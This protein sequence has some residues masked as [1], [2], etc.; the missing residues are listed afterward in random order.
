MEPDD[1]GAAPSDLAAQNGYDTL[2]KELR[3]LE[4]RTLRLPV[5][6][7]EGGGDEVERN[8][9]ARERGPRTW[10]ADTGGCTRRAYEP[11][12]RL[13]SPSEEDY[14]IVHRR[15]R[16]ARDPAPLPARVPW[17]SARRSRRRRSPRGRRP[18][19]RE[20]I[21]TRAT[22]HLR[23][24]RPRAR[25]SLRRPYARRGV[26][27]LRVAASV[28][29]ANSPRVLRRRR[30]NRL[31]RLRHYPRGPFDVALRA[32]STRGVRVL[33]LRREYRRM[34]SRPRLGAESCRLA[35]REGCRLAPRSARV[36]VPRRPRRRARVARVS[37]TPHSRPRRRRR[38]CP[39]R[40]GWRTR[41]R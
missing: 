8:G 26:P 3:E 28:D 18:R 14:P 30:S 7:R 5:V 20:R 15:A 32:P 9:R 40:R 38:S 17:P 37:T 24:R 4:D 33:R 12:R 27:A 34:K 29:D 16:L 2:A 13:S 10:S 19:P 11:A 1:R 41:C 25:P 21:S 35:P 23:P 31:D 36:R 22:S 39:P 6:F